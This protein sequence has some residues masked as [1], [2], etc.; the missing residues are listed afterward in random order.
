MKVSDIFEGVPM[1]SA[2]INSATKFQYSM[3]FEIEL[4]CNIEHFGEN[5]GNV[6]SKTTHLYKLI[7]NDFSK[8]MNVHQVIDDSSIELDGRYQIGAEIISKP[9]ATIDEGLFAL[10]KALAKID[11]INYKTNESCGL[12]VTLGKFSKKDINKI[13]LLK[14]YLLINGDM[15]L[16]DYAREDNEYCDLEYI[17]EVLLGLRDEHIVKYIQLYN[18][19]IPKINKYFESTSR[20]AKYSFI[21]IAKLFET[22]LIEIRA[23]G[24]TGYEKRFSSIEKH[25]KYIVRALDI[26]RDPNA[27]RNEYLKKIYK[28]IDS[29][30]SDRSENLQIKYKTLMTIKD[31]FDLSFKDIHGTELFFTAISENLQNS[32]SKQLD[33]INKTLTA[34]IVRVLKKNFINTS[35]E[36][37]QLTKV[38]FEKFMTTNK[39]YEKI[40]SM[41]KYLLA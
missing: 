29:D 37:K 38:N 21:N 26:A 25:V 27:Y 40:N 41:I 2:D 17:G 9:Y 33:K 16:R 22:G 11:G 28:F 13:D 7:K 3:G 18:A 6:S 20:D 15:I 19:S 4:V 32:K 5:F 35:D 1:G 8:V 10:K 39:K 23:F 14:F 30:S 24:N 31:L 36:V 34:D 12:H